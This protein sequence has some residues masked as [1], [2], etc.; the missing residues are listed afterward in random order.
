MPATHYPSILA[1][2][3]GTME[4][5]FI[6][7]NFHYIKVVTVSNGSGWAVPALCKQIGSKYAINNSNP[8]LVVVWL[9]KEKKVCSL[10]EFGAAIRAE[11]IERGADPNKLAICIPNRMTENIILADEIIIR[12]ELN[13]EYTYIYEGTN[14]KRVLSELFGKAEKT[15]RETTDGV[16]LLKKLRLERAARKS[17]SASYFIRQL[18]VPCWWVHGDV[19]SV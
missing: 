15:Y 13:M 6:N 16:R 2:V 19:L 9:D 18:S 5:I 1:F 8:D 10:D 11:L 7:N 14:G 12:K 3:E 17:P 4:R